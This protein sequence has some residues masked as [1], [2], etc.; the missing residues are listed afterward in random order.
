MS[1]VRPVNGDVSRLVVQR[2]G[3]GLSGMRGI[4][5]VVIGNAGRWAIAT[6]RFGSRLGL[7]KRGGEGVSQPAVSKA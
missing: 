3:W 1:A 4:A 5:E 7:S 2:W 6:S